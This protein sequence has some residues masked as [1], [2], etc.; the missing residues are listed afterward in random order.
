MPPSSDSGR[1]LDC[2]RFLELQGILR[3]ANHRCQRSIDRHKTLQPSHHHASKVA[4]R[5][6]LGVNIELCNQRRCMVP[7]PVVDCDLVQSPLKSPPTHKYFNSLISAA[8]DKISCKTEIP[9]AEQK[10][11]DMS[12]GSNNIISMDI[13]LDCGSQPLVCPVSTPLYMI[14]LFSHLNIL[15]VV[16]QK[17]KAPD[18]AS[19]SGHGKKRPKFIKVG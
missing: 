2:H 6:A 5:L 13:S 4:Q 14:F 11:G 16:V 10:K 15:I 19:A 7:L 12:W 3:E 9:I 17:R 1:P 18:D 8:H